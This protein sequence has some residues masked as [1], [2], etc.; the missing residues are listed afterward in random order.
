MKHSY[1]YGTCNFTSRAAAHRYYAGYGFDANDVDSKITAG[2]IAIGEPT[3]KSDEKL[4]PI[5]DGGRY[6]V[7]VFI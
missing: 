5:E 3:L 2:E 1:S 7:E 4:G 6:T